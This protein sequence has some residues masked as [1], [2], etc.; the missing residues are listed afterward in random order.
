MA[1]VT[2]LLTM[3]S[4]ARQEFSS[5][6]ITPQNIE[7]QDLIHL[8][9]YVRDVQLKINTALTELMD[10][11]SGGKGDGPTTTAND[12]EDDEEPD[13]EDL[14]EVEE[15]TDKKLCLAQNGLPA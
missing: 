12:E 10:M 15:P 5:S 11:E 6:S 7:Q 1:N 3:K 4:G 2:A 9:E 13:D 14:N 8:R